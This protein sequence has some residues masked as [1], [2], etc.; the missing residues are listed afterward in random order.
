MSVF[1]QYNL[2]LKAAELGSLTLAAEAMGCT[3]SNV[4]HAVSALE[5]ELGVP[6]LTRGRKGA[7]LT[8]EGERLLP[9]MQ[10]VCQDGERLRRAAEALRGGETGRLRVGSFTSVAV[11]WLPRII[12]G[13]QAR[14]PGISFELLNGDYGDVEQ[15]LA[16][17]RV[18]AAFTRLPC[19]LN[20]DFLPLYKDRLMAILPPEHPRA[21]D[22]AFPLSA[23]AG[24]TLISL[25]EGSD[26]DSIR[27]LREA[28]LDPVIGFTT[29]DD[30]A[31]IAMV[32]NGLGIS[33]VPELLLAGRGDR[34]ARLP[35]EPPATRTIAL[36]IPEANRGSAAVQ[37]F[38][39]FVREWAGSA[40]LS[41]QAIP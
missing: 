25:P 9:L 23:I 24:E 19:D 36:A 26:H 29:K 40:A 38:A 39:D 15:W 33:I 41:G 18:D 31:L 11:H 1:F 14:Y 4:S 20:C 28:G 2:F 27:T 8:P 17:G 10:A 7:R 32:E 34:V 35:L 13:F 22:A 21:H 16:A 37:R 6:L 5:K 3:Q 12:K 30:Y